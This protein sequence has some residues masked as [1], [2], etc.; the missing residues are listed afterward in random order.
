MYVSDDVLWPRS[1]FNAMFLV[2]KV[3][4]SGWHILC[5]S[6]ILVEKNAVFLTS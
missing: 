6:I 4:S 3:I 1:I 2:F 5:A